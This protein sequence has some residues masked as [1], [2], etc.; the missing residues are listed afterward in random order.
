MLSENPF[1]INKS[2]KSQGMMIQGSF[3][4]IHTNVEVFKPS[5]KLLSRSLTSSINVT[6]NENKHF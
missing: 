1:I 6:F 2:V 5:D 3:I 4:M